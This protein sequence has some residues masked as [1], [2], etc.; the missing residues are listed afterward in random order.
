MAGKGDRPRPVNKKRYDENYEKIFG[1]KDEKT[2]TSKRGK[3][4]KTPRRNS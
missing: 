2:K 1:K 4:T 3:G